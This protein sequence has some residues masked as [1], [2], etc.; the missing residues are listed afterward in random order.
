MIACRVGARASAQFR[1]RSALSTTIV[2]SFQAFARRAPTASPLAAN[3]H[4]DFWV[5]RCNS[6]S[7]P[8]GKTGAPWT[9]KRSSVRKQAAGRSHRQR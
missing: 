2:L 3:G 1:I 6:G 7:A 5:T 9:G 4:R 8:A